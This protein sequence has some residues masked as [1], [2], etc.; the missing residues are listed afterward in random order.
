MA[1]KEQGTQMS[2]TKVEHIHIYERPTWNK[3][4]Y[5]CIDPGCPHYIKKGYLLGK[6][7]R[8]PECSNQFILTREK[9]L[10]ARPKCDFCSNTKR[11]KEL[12]QVAS[13]QVLQKI[14][15]DIQTPVD[16]VENGEDK[17]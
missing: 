13:N 3:T 5:R 14:F 10:R 7:A 1:I 2:K 17:L 11:A 8:C 6:Y 15:E 4:I 16:M 12:Q 9:L